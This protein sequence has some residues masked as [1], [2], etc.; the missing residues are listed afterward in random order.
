MPRTLLTTFQTWLPHQA[1][2]SSDDLIAHLLAIAALPPDTHVLRQ[3]PVDYHRAPAEVIQAIDQIQ[4][5]FVL[6]CGMAELR[7][8]LTVESNGQW[9]SHHCFTPIDLQ[10]LISGTQATVISHHAGRFVC[11]YLYY[12]VLRYLAI[13]R[14]SPITT[15]QFSLWNEAIGFQR[16]AS[17]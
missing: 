3:I 8:Q 4:P 1:S 11:N 7:T 5:D 9:Q 6:C 10:A 15:Q 17:L 13:E 2:N 12:Q 14:R 16:F